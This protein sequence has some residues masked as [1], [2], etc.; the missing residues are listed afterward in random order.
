MAMV[1]RCMAAIIAGMIVA[2]V[3]VVERSKQLAFIKALGA[4]RKRDTAI[5]YMKGYKRFWLPTNGLDEWHR[6]HPSLNPTG[7]GTLRWSCT[8]PTEQNISRHEGVN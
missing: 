8:N 2:L 4:K 5:A 1:L 7:T 3:F 6:L